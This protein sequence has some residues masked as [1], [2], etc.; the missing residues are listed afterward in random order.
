M[1]ILILFAIL[2]G[3][4][5]LWGPVV[6]AVLLVPVQQYLAFQYGAS[7]LYLIGY[8]V[9]FLVVIYLLPQGIVPSGQRYLGHLRRFR[10]SRR[11]T[12][13]SATRLV[14]SDPAQEPH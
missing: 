4:R 13:A 1:L 5:S 3:V 2:G 6:G 9:V 12:A 14:A 10:E 7:H 8:A 11:S